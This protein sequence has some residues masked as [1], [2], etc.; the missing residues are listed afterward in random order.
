M[1]SRL[2]YRTQRPHEGPARSL[3]TAR[4]SDRRSIRFFEEVGAPT[5]DNNMHFCV[6]HASS[7]STVPECDSGSQ[8]N[9]WECLGGV[10]TYSALTRIL[11][12]LA[13]PWFAGC[14][15]N[16][17]PKILGPVSLLRAMS[18]IPSAP[19]HSDSISEFLLL[20]SPR[21]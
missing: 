15:T 8:L 5:L 11:W 10:E 13:Y 14:R 4:R 20:G 9:S 7:R 6:E 1:P 17:S 3:R 12:S 19:T 21:M 2:R 16:T 18:T